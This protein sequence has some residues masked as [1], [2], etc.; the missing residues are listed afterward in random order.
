MDS[1]TIGFIG[2]GH[3]AQAIISGLLADDNNTIPASNIFATCHSQSSA[4]Q[5][6]ERCG[7]DCKTNN[8]WLVN[9]A[10]VVILAVKPQQIRSVLEEISSYDLNEKIIVTLAA[11]INCSAYRKFIGDDLPLVRAMPNIGAEVNA[12]LTGIYADQDLSDEDAGLIEAI[13]SAVGEIAW[14]DDEVQIDGITAI[15]GSGIAYFFRFMQAMAKAGERYGFEHDE[16]YD[17]VTLTAMGAATLAL[18]ND[19]EKPD[20]ADLCRSVAVEGGTTAQALSVFEQAE[21]DRVV[22]QAMDAVVSK[23]AN[24]RQSLTKDW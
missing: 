7:I 2:C 19:A 10:D 15:A 14:L 11:A 4:E 5:A 23:S 24:L 17:L 16:V 22:A 12:S 8:Q 9:Q 21:L 1:P 13:F 6:N 3:M 18:E 20:F